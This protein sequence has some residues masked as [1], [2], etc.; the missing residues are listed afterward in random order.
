[1]RRFKRWR[2]KR[3]FK[4]AIA[5][6]IKADQAMREMGMPKKMR[7]QMWRDFVRSPENRMNLYKVL[8]GALNGTK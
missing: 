3:Q 1:M 8:D 7:K 5:L 2:T 4:R 6:L